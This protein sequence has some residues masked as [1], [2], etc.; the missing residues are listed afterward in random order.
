MPLTNFF[1]LVN[2]SFSYLIFYF[3]GFLMTGYEPKENSPFY[4]KRTWADKIK[5]RKNAFYSSFDFYTVHMRPDL[6]VTS[7]VIFVPI[8]S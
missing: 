5:K 1:Y 8:N 2:S 6:E 3:T 4:R 7:K